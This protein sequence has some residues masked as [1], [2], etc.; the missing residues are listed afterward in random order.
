VGFKEARKVMTVVAVS[1]AKAERAF[2][3]M[4]TLATDKSAL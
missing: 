3:L 4:K 2:R 1:S